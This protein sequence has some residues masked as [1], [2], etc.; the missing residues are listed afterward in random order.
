MYRYRG[1]FTP[2]LPLPTGH[3][4]RLL[5]FPWEWQAVKSE[6]KTVENIRFFA[7]ARFLEFCMKPEPAGDLHLG[8]AK[9]RGTPQIPRGFWFGKTQNKS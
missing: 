7:Q 2:P 3:F 9:T 5:N 8:T 1:G 6:P 4:H